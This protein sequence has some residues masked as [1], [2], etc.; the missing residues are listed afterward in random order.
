M[1]KTAKA[2]L[3]YSSLFAI[4]MVASAI[5][6]NPTPQ[7]LLSQAFFLPVVIFLIILTANEFNKKSSSQTV[8]TKKRLISLVT[9]LLILFA[10]GLYSITA[11]QKPLVSGE[12]TPEKANYVTVKKPTGSVQPKQI[13]KSISIDSKGIGYVN[14]REKP[15]TDSLILLRAL[16][17]DNFVVYSDEDGWYKIA[18]AAGN[19]GYVSKTYTKLIEEA[20]ASGQIN[21][22]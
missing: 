14:I 6:A 12:N 16:D 20:S 18:T 2:I 3:V 17:N 22:P 8:L 1:N 11:N 4:F 10:I 21:Q 7:T 19:F 15:S 9:L 13:Q 5:I